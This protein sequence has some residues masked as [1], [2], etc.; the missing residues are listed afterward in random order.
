[1]GVDPDTTS[2]ATIHKTSDEFF[3]LN[4]ENFDIIF[5]DGLHLHENCT[6]DISNAL[7]RL[8]EGGIV[9]CHDMLPTTEHMQV[10][11]NHGGAWTGDVWRSFVHYREDD[12]LTMHTVNTDY[13]IGLIEFGK[14]E[15]LII[16][17]ELTYENFVK[18]KQEW[19]N[20]ISVEEF[21]NLY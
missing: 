10:R 7:F 19:M 2:A 5:I 4:K 16:K 1:V 8:N 6:K 12:C 14:Q 20:I 21:L 15:P 11:E 13:G 17:E 3:L 9:V 18:N